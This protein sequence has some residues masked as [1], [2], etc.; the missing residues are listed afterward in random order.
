MRPVPGLRGTIGIHA[1]STRPFRYTPPTSRHVG[2]FARAPA[3][4]T[5][6]TGR[7]WLGAAPRSSSGMCVAYPW[8][9]FFARH[10][11]L[12]PRERT[13]VTAAAPH[14]VADATHS[15]ARARGTHPRRAR[16]DRKRLVG[17]RRHAP[18]LLRHRNRLASARMGIPPRGRRRS[19]HAAGMVCVKAGIRDS[20]IG[21]GQGAGSRRF[22]CSDS[23]SYAELH[24]LSA[25]SFQRGASVAHELFERA[26]RL[27]YTALAITDEASLAGIV[28]ALEASRSEE[29]RV[30]KEVRDRARAQLWNKKLTVRKTY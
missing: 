4:A 8:R 6:R 2:G 18:R 5:G 7:A 15:L 17:R 25:F 3:C 24:C 9:R 19:F 1:D 12:P 13:A 23:P 22:H 30:G 10:Q 21:N 26:A 27:K 20:G 16:T 28:R 14:L 29:R 11:R